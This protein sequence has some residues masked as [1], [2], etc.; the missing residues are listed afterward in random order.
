MVEAL[1]TTSQSGEKGKDKS[2]YLFSPLALQQ[3]KFY[4]VLIV[5]DRE[6]TTADYLF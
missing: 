6:R 1:E 3:R 5:K 2:F 4:C